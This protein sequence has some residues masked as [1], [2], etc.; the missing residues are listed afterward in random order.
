VVNVSNLTDTPLTT[1]GGGD[2][3]VP[4]GFNGA[5]EGISSN[6]AAIGILQNTPAVIAG[7]ATLQE[8]GA[9]ADLTTNFLY[10]VVLPNTHVQPY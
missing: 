10:P 8:F 1:T 6:S 2:Y 7:K 5:L 9:A 4:A 3:V